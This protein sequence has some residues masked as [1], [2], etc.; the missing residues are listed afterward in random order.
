MKTVPWQN[1]DLLT[2]IYVNKSEKTC[3]F[4]EKSVHLSESL[5]PSA[6]LTQNASATFRGLPGFSPSLPPLGLPSH[7]A[8][9]LG[10]ARGTAVLCPPPP[11]LQAYSLCPCGGSPNSKSTPCTTAVS[12]VSGSPVFPLY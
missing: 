10:L 4:L 9:A 6:L 3:P 12:V 1:R 2:A 11:N 7:L 8:P 5:S